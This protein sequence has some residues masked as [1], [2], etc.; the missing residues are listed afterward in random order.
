MS[1]V[2]IGIYRGETRETASREADVTVTKRTTFKALRKT[3]TTAGLM[4]A[5]DEFWGGKEAIDVEKEDTTKVL[6][7]AAARGDGKA[8]FVI[9]PEEE[10]SDVS[11]RLDGCP[12][13]FA[14][15]VR[16]LTHN[17]YLAR[18]DLGGKL[19]RI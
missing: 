19:G 15:V 17:W 13:V 16:T 5:D 3:L 2:N 11:C 18:V 12:S 4:D 7:H 1:K 8:I 14:Q 6:P 9:T 10:E